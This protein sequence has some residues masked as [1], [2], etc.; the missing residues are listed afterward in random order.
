MIARNIGLSYFLELL[1]VD[2]FYDIF[3]CAHTVAIRPLARLLTR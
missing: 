1:V 3:F 2:L